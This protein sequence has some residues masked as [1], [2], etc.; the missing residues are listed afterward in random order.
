[1][2]V[3]VKGGDARQHLL[4]RRAPSTSDSGL[5][6]PLNGG[7]QNPQISHVVFCFDPKEGPIADAERARRPR[8]ARRR[9]A[10]LGGRQAGQGGGCV[11]C[12]VRRQRRRSTCRTAGQRL[13]H[14]EGDG[15]AL[16]GADVRRD[17]HDQARQQRT[18]AVTGVD[19]SDSMPGA[20]IDCGNG[21]STGVTVP[22]N[23]TVNCAYSV[24]PGSQ[25]PNNTATA[26]WGSGGSAQAT[27]TIAVGGSDRG[28]ARP[29]PSWTAASR[30]VRSTPA[31]SRTTR[32][33]RRTTSGGRAERHAVAEHGS[34]EHGHRHVGRRH[35]LRQ[36]ERPG[37]LRQHAA[38]AAAH[39]A[40]DSGDTAGGTSH[41]RAGR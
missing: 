10:Q 5:T 19:V 1:M 37:R 7:G 39:A 36:R 29:R 13:V 8:P 14:L 27:A 4:L 33:R 9:S 11:R 2:A 16:A 35:G 12:D 22:A 6:P 38:A 30:R 21:Q 18:V 26:T 15:H 32:G 31:I 25:V 20:V 3:I 34:H 24:T 40:D 41:G 28:R 23:S 17:G